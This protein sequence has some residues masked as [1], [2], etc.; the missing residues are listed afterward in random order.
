MI[1]KDII[2]NDIGTSIHSSHN[3]F[4]DYDLIFAHFFSLT[5]NQKKLGSICASKISKKE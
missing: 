1:Q 3:Y 2:E 5:L 4:K